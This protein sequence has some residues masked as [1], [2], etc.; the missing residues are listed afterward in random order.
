[1][2]VPIVNNEVKRLLLYRVPCRMRVTSCIGVQHLLSHQQLKGLGCRATLLSIQSHIVST[3]QPVSNPNNF[4]DTVSLA[5][6]MFT[7]LSAC[8]ETQYTDRIFVKQELWKWSNC[9]EH[10][11]STVERCLGCMCSD[12]SIT[13]ID[14]TI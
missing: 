13:S 2:R 11:L 8:V 12:V 1:M 14:P 10:T 7:T 6:I 9:M 3:D 4:L 5:K